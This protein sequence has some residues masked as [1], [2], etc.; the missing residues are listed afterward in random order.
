MMTM[1]QAPAASRE[2]WNPHFVAEASG[3]I[4]SPGA[5]DRPCPF[6]GLSTDS[7]TAGADQWFVAL[8][9]PNFNGHDFIA[10]AYA[11]G[12]RGFVVQQDYRPG[13]A[14]AADAVFV[15]VKDTLKALGDIARRH[16][17]RFSVPV[18]AITG[19]NGKTTTKEMTAAIMERRFSG[20]VLATQGNFNNLIGLPLTIA[21]WT[22]EHQAAVLEMGMSMRGEIRRLAEIARADIGVITNVSPVHLEHLT[23][24][25]DVAEAKREL[26][27]RFGPGQV[28]VL[29]AD[30]AL[31]QEMG[32]HGD[33]QVRTFGIDSPADVRAED[34]VVHGFEGIGFTIQVDGQAAP[35]MLT[36]V[37]RHNV[38]NA[39]AA[40]AAATRA[41]ATL[42][43]VVAGLESFRPAAMRMRI[44]DILHVKVL[45]DTYNASPRSMDAALSTLKELAGSGRRVAVMGDMREL[46]AE[47]EAAHRRI[48]RHVAKDGVDWLFVYGESVRHTVDGALEERMNPERVVYAATHAEIVARLRDL[49]ER[50]DVV[51]VKGSRA[52]RMELVVRGL[53]GET[54]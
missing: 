31:V 1:G 34:V 48:G 54:L 11:A 49:L 27:E 28:A 14:M 20:R 35:V 40:A 46:G 43:D 42:D 22:G 36:C 39:L 5:T 38:Q 51:L 32:R 8:S 19:S 13:P 29:N 33:F 6:A 2:Y 41:G 25:R 44:L 52:M 30:D 47:T 10:A 7:R 26:L 9:G 37:G 23:N 15:F 17:E 53:K 18:I 16:R 50:G 24:I 12:V 45:D 4:L 21:R 3:G